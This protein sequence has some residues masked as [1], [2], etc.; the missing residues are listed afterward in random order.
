MGGLS[1]RCWTSSHTPYPISL[2]REHPSHLHRTTIIRCKSTQNRKAVSDLTSPLTHRVCLGPAC[3]GDRRS[4]LH[5]S[6]FLSWA[7]CIAQELDKLTVLLV[8]SRGANCVAPSVQIQLTVSL[9]IWLHWLCRAAGP[10]SWQHPMHF[11]PLAFTFWSLVLSRPRRPRNLWPNRFQECRVSLQL[12]SMHYNSNELY[13]RGLFWLLWA[14]ERCEWKR[15]VGCRSEP[16]RS[17]M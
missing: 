1:Y 14:R 15:V 13:S 5:C 10:Q 16:P 17:Y 4:W 12:C 11:S 8:P 9:E 3:L 6:S 7:D 2:H